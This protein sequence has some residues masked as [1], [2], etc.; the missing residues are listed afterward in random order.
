MRAGRRIL[1]MPLFIMILLLSLSLSAAEIHP[2][3]ANRA[4]SLATISFVS[5]IE[6][7]GVVLSGSGLPPQ[8]ELYYRQIGAA[9][10][11]PAHPLLRTGDGRLVGSLFGLSPA[12][13]YDVRV[14]AGSSEITGS[15]STQP[16]QLS[17]TPSTI[18][19]VDDGALPGGDG[20]AAAPYQTIQEAVNH[21]GPG[22]QVLVAD[23][24]YREAV[25]FPVSGTE[26]KWLQ[27]KAEGNAA[28]LDSADPLSG[29]IWT[30]TST[31]K[32]WFTKVNGPVA[33]LA[34]SGTRFYQYDDLAGLNQ[35][36]GH[37]GI[38]IKEGWFYE[39][40][41]SKLYIRSLD[42]PAAHLWQLPRLNHAFDVSARDWLWIEGFE[43][44]FYGTTTNGCGVCTLNSSHVV[45]RR[46]KIHNMQLGIFVNWNGAATQGN[47]TR[48]EGNEI[49]DPGIY[50]WPWAALKASYMEGTGIIVRGHIGA[51]VRENT[52]HS[53]FNG[54]Y[55][56]SS[57]AL[58]NFELAFDGDI[59]RNH[60]YN[61]SDDGLEPEGACIN[62]RFR[63]NTVDRSFI[64]ISVAPVTQ[65]PAWV[66]RNIFSGFTG[67]A[68]KFADDSDGIVLIY[69]NT[70]WTTV[71]NVNGADLITAV[72]H[73]TMRNNIFQSTGYSINAVPTGSTSNDWNHDDWYTTRGTAGPHFKWENVNYNT[74]S[75]L[76]KASALE[77]NGSE[78]VP[79]FANPV[80][81]DFTLLASSPNVDH[82]IPIPGINDGFAGN[83]PDSGAYEFAAVSAPLA[84]LSIT[85]VD[86]NPTGAAS[87]DYELTFSKPVTGV[88][89]IPPFTD[90][91]LSTGSELA[92]AAVTT[93]TA[94]SGSTYRVSVNTGSGNGTLRL[95]LVDDDS[96]I[97]VQGNPLGG[98]GAGNGDFSAGETYTVNRSITNLVTAGFRSTGAYDGWVLE[99]G[100]NS[101]AGGTLDRGAT[102]ISVGDDARNRQY[103][104]ILSFNTSSLPDNAVIVAVQVKVKRQGTVGTNPY[105]THGAL[106]VEI[107]GG[108]FS[109]NIGLQKSD[110]SDP[111]STGSV[112][113]QMIPITSSWYAAQL[114]PANLPLVSRTGST[115]FRLFFSRDDND[116]RSADSIRFYSGNSASANVP[117]LIVMYY[118]P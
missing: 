8:G 6:T 101:N 80:G 109:N 56:G 117:Q 88:D 30:Q 93:V 64:G 62:Q 99:S 5:N 81:G 34:R 22:T 105:A 47:D 61:I 40:G 98:V 84:V 89:V 18:L 69:H 11:H 78:A 26:G 110:F 25:T 28:I 73:V 113:D 35:A 107:R 68:I 43:I 91:K 83:A 32:V 77:C 92:G 94:T 114:A 48:I 71:G 75:A 66:L 46:N 100:E 1:S 19:H 31:S 39:P 15:A 50:D 52:V 20:S 7:I 82:G 24:T 108:A 44:R 45:I 63:N 74:I 118:V 79:G 57:G 36:R 106:L 95:D 97:D 2:L 33:Y 104:G 17:F 90:F 86:S 60:M 55:V 13:S 53:Y 12:T 58:E 54:I 67:R 3:S 38:A 111:A 27:V 16:D 21:A 4:A 115:Q 116:D 29:N 76:C 9:D 70:S 72:H 14:V 85:R 41:T 103:R 102:T 112:R 42:N 87:V 65:G 37:G 49:Y 10:W 59:Y 23:G 96:I 51:I